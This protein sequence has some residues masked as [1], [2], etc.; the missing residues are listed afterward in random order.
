MARVE[1]Q[2]RFSEQVLEMEEGRR[3]RDANLMGTWTASSIT[4]TGTD[5]EITLNIVDS[6]DS[7]TY[8]D[9]ESE[10]KP[11]TDFGDWLRA[12]YNI[13]SDF[14]KGETGT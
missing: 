12:K 6:T 4:T 11:I 13:E 2:D 7:I 14:C 1:A 3:Q 10:P 9:V 8:D 5:G